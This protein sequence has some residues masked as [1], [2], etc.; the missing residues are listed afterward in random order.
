MSVRFVPLPLP[1]GGFVSVRHTLSDGD[2][3]AYPD[4]W[5]PPP[6]CTR[7]SCFYV[8]TSPTWP[9]YSRSGPCLTFRVGYQCCCCCCSVYTLSQHTLRGKAA[10]DIGMAISRSS[11]FVRKNVGGIFLLSTG[12]VSFR[13]SV[14]FSSLPWVSRPIPPMRTVHP[15][16]AATRPSN[17]RARRRSPNSCHRSTLKPRK[18]LPEAVDVLTHTSLPCRFHTRSSF[19]A[20]GLCARRGEALRRCPQIPQIPPSSRR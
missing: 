6:P 11:R 18:Q 14:L 9:V 15:K 16:A 13:P 4:T 10:G 17:A 8:A 7:H 3:I 20:C 19:L 12:W 5:E 1:R 2:A